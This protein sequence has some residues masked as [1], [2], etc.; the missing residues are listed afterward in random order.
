M[1]KSS[2]QE[3]LL[4]YYYNETDLIDGDAI[5]RQIDGDPLL[6]NDYKELCDALDALDFYKVQPSDK[7]IQK[8]LAYAGAM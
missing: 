7:S 8:I 2:T 3:N 1:I 4:R 5:Q 6:N